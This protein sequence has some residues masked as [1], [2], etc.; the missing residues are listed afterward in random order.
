MILSAFA[1][2]KGWRCG[3]HVYRDCPKNGGLNGSGHLLLLR[4][5]LFAMESPPFFALLYT[6]CLEN[7]VF[8]ALV[9]DEVE[10]AHQLRRHSAKVNRRSDRQQYLLCTAVQTDL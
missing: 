7:G 3:Y 4:E 2:K 1:D 10:I 8:C 6:E 5:R 9:E